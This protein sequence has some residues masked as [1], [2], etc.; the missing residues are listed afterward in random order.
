MNLGDVFWVEFPPQSGHPQSG[1]RP[2]IVAQVA[3][4]TASL[5]TIL[6]IPLTTQLAAL[7]FPGTVM[8][9][10]DQENGLR[11]ASVA[12]VFQL[13][14]VDQ[15]VVA[16]RMGRISETVLTSIWEEMD[17]LTGRGGSEPVG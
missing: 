8:V 1:R 3:S 16:P 15:R 14:V 12:L 2:A 7:R 13:T 4:A 17:R 5:P 10:A 11:R 6:M 9:D